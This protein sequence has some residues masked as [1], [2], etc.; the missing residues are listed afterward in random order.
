[1]TDD[2]A[3]I[4]LIAEW[5]DR[6]ESC[7]N[8]FGHKVTDAQRDAFLR[9]FADVTPEQLHYAFSECE[10][11]HEA[12]QGFPCPGDVRKYLSKFQ[13]T[14]EDLDA[15]QVWLKV[16]WICAQFWRGDSGLLPIY[17]T[18]APK[19]PQWVDNCDITPDETNGIPGFKITPKRFSERILYAIRMV[20]G[21]DKIAEPGETHDFCRR[22]FLRF[23]RDFSTGR[24]DN[25]LPKAEA[26]ALLEGLANEQR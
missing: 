6:Y 22:D 10:K 19:M 4:A 5:L 16:R 3:R 24:F 15:Q 7:L 1:M 17:I 18:N 13:A 21:L 11:H 20:G 23:Y 26:K 9:A 25:Q 8:N 2:P 12:K 14:T